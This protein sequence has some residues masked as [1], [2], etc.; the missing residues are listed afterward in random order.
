MPKRRFTF[1]PTNREDHEDYIKEETS[2]FRKSIR[3]K[4]NESFFFK[5]I[6]YIRFGKIRDKKFGNGTKKNF[7]EQQ[8]E[9]GTLFNDIID[10]LN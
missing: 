5:S 6:F 4:Q 7:H 2:S 1:A 10:R 3:W 8:I 9:I